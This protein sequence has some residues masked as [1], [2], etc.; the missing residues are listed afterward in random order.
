MQ[1]FRDG[2]ADAPL[3]GLSRVRGLGLCRKQE[4]SWFICRRRPA[5]LSDRPRRPRLSGG[6]AS[7]ASFV[8][9]AVI[10][11]F[12][13]FNSLY[14]SLFSLLTLLQ[15]SHPPLAIPPQPHPP[16]AG[17]HPLWS[18]SLAHAPPCSLAGPFP[19][20]HPAPPLPSDSCQSAPRHRCCVLR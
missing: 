8:V 9:S 19:F 11:T 1:G 6:L 2:C 3:G 17:H 7:R 15:M 4:P 18:V 14:F 20:S 10:A 5:L 13:L 16:S 12:Y